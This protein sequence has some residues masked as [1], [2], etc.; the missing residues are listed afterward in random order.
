MNLANYIKEKLSGTTHYDW[1]I[2]ISW[3]GSV[4]INY[5]YGS[6]ELEDEGYNV[7]AT[8]R[9]SDHTRPSVVTDGG[10]FDHSYL[11]DFRVVDNKIGKG[12]VDSILLYADYLIKQAKQE[13][14]EENH[15]CILWKDSDFNKIRDDL[16]TEGTYSNDFLTLQEE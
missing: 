14:E 7:R 11:K 3:S 13:L 10:V 4:Y 8:I 9:F 1:S 16:I 12:Y 5:E 15:I 6:E 2:D